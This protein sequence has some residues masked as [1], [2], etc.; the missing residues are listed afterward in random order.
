[1]HQVTIVILFEI[2]IL[3]ALE[4]DGLTCSRPVLRCMCSEPSDAR[5]AD[6]QRLSS[7]LIA[8]LDSILC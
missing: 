5:C 1:M 4:S 3:R 2:G 8:F 7:P 6:P